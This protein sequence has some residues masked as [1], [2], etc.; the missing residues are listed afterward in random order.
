M[1][2]SVESQ[3][4]SPDGFHDERMP[5]AIRNELT[6]IPLLNLAKVVIEVVELD[7]YRW[8]LFVAKMPAKKGSDKI[9]DSIDRIFIRGA[10]IHLLIDYDFAHKLC[11]DNIS[12]PDFRQSLPSSFQARLILTRVP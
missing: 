1:F 5:L 10:F 8:H 9:A 4:G 11:H 12:P 7:G 6:D 3:Q 2:L